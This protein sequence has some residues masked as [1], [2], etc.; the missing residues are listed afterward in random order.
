MCRDLLGPARTRRDL[1]GPAATCRD[2]PRPA[3]TCRDT[4]PGVTRAR[5]P[6]RTRQLWN[7]VTG[8][9]GGQG[10]SG[11]CAWC[12]DQQSPPEDSLSWNY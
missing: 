4:P 10:A 12:W 11:N 1:L 8:A 6:A 7:D 5:G 9:A 2:L 3:G